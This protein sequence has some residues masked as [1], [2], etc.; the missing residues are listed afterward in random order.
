MQLDF[1]G[2]WLLWEQIKFPHLCH[3]ISFHQNMDIEA[4]AFIKVKLIMKNYLLKIPLLK[5]RNLYLCKIARSSPCGLKIS[6]LFFRQFSAVWNYTKKLCSWFFS[7][8][9]KT[10]VSRNKCS[11]KIR[12]LQYYTH[13][14]GIIKLLVYQL[15]WMLMGIF[16]SFWQSDANIYPDKIKKIVYNSYMLMFWMCPC[17]ISG[18][19]HYLPERKVKH[20]MYQLL[21]SVEHMHR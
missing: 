12:N 5:A 4:H 3:C 20:Y 14:L 21:K 6:L 19:R 18:K 10:V 9:C 2:F 17:M 15:D 16:Y 11:R 8:W 1:G 13:M 7:I